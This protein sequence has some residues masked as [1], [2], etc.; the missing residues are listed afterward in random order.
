MM[1]SNNTQLA[2]TRRRML[3]YRTNSRAAS[4]KE[5]RCQHQGEPGEAGERIQKEHEPGRAI[6]DC[7]QQLPEKT[8]DAAARSKP[9]E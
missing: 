5:K 9:E 4:I 8:A 3:K 1:A 2:F 7:E 6:N